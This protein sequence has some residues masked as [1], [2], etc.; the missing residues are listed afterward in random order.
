MAEQ[1]HLLDALAIDAYYDYLND[2]MKVRFSKEVRSED[3]FAEEMHDQCYLVRAEMEERSRLMLELERRAG[4][5]AGATY[6][7]SLR[8][9]QKKDAQKLVTGFSIGSC[10]LLADGSSR[11]S[12]GGELIVSVWFLT[13]FSAIVSLSVGVV[14]EDVCCRTSC[15][16]DVTE[17]GVGR[18]S[19]G[20]GDV[21]KAASRLKLGWPG[22]ALL[23]KRSLQS[24]AKVCASGLKQVRVA[25]SVPSSMLIRKQYLTDFGNGCFRGKACSLS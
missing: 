10:K 3:A 1:C 25:V 23:P 14:A 11:I 16:G 24:G 22:L 15:G 4:G 18:P 5:D 8:Q 13:C 6:I 12:A 9:M 19:S 2:Q 20:C 17:S 7:E 21:L